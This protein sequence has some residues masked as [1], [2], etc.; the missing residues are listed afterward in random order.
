MFNIFQRDL[1]PSTSVS[2]LPF[3]PFEVDA[4][5]PDGRNLK[6]PYAKEFLSNLVNSAEELLHRQDQDAE[7]RLTA[8]DTKI[9]LL[10][11]QVTLVN[12]EV[13]L[14]CRDLNLEVA[15]NE[16]EHDGRINER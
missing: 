16:E 3:Y 2:V 4:F 14:L 7:T 15:R 5:E 8:V 10:Q 13:S 9:E 1:K 6:S 12:E 11:G